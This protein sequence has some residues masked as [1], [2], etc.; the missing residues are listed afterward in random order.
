M[1]QLEALLGVAS[2]C[3]PHDA[4]TALPFA[5]QLVAALT[6]RASSALTERAS[7]ALT[8]RASLAATPATSCDALKRD[9]QIGEPL[10]YISA[11]LDILSDQ[12]CVDMRPAALKNGIRLHSSTW[13]RLVKV[14]NR[15][16]WHRPPPVAIDTSRAADGMLVANLQLLLRGS[17]VNG[18][19]LSRPETSQA[20]IAVAVEALRDHRLHLLAC[21]CRHGIGIGRRPVVPPET[22]HRISDVKERIVELGLLTARGDVARPEL[23]GVPID[24]ALV[25]QL[26]TRERVCVADAA[27]A[28]ALQGTVEA[29]CAHVRAT[30]NGV[31]PTEGAR[32]AGDG[33][34]THEDGSF[35]QLLPVDGTA[36]AAVDGAEQA[37]VDAPR[38]CPSIDDSTL[39]QLARLLARRSATPPSTNLVAAALAMRRDYSLSA[40]AA[41][42]TVLASTSGSLAAAS[43]ASRAD[44][45]RKEL[46]VLEMRERLEALG[47]L[48]DVLASLPSQE[49]SAASS[50]WSSLPLD[51]ERWLM[52]VQRVIGNV[53][54]PHESH[55]PSG[56]EARPVEL[57][58]LRVALELADAAHK[59]IDPLCG[60][61]GVDL[62]SHPASKRGYIRDVRDRIQERGLAKV[63]PHELLRPT[64]APAHGDA[65]VRSVQL[66]LTKGF[67]WAQLPNADNVALALDIHTESGLDVPTACFRRGLSYGS[68]RKKAVLQLRDAL[69]ELVPPI[70]ANVEDA[71]V[72]RALAMLV[73]S[74]VPGASQS[75]GS[76]A[77]AVAVHGGD[78]LQVVNALREQ[79]G[80]EAV[81]G[82]LLKPDMEEEE[83]AGS[84]AAAEAPRLASFTVRPEPISAALLAEI[85]RLASAS[86]RVHETRLAADRFFR[87]AADLCRT[88]MRDVRFDRIDLAQV[89]G[90]HEIPLDRRQNTERLKEVRPAALPHSSSPQPL[91]LP[92]VPPPCSAARSPP[93]SPPCSPPPFHCPT[94][95]EA[96]Q[97][98]RAARD[99]ASSCL[100][101]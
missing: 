2:D 22:I 75:I 21:L 14:I 98:V 42:Q 59:G 20:T 37:A 44:V 89:C 28:L 73:R 53:C 18:S 88:G 78:V 82:A 58:Y 6:E 92:C 60:K 10:P 34:G 47:A 95:A 57:P 13:E 27:M 83:A 33:D 65:L 40:Q 36:L 99:A 74:G 48:D 79:R 97:I 50:S 77:N 31:T 101:P 84:T 64:S 93:C 76:V 61:H 9:L 85:K 72:K 15:L 67:T 5:E 24:P 3:S 39:A 23:L 90:W 52:C 51:D 91:L 86:W 69:S 41:L 1:A 35:E 29:A 16:G 81:D 96:D 26:R 66:R 11:A 43:S 7:S 38:K 87:A 63:P 62:S 32:I 71:T 8:E 45:R 94:V 25:E 55:C 17:K 68:S 12:S 54:R 100:A 49:G 19:H 70:D 80:K 30:R 4:A 46:L 56:S